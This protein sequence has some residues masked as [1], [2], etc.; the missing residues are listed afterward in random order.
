MQA[1]ASI[2]VGNR[3]FYIISEVISVEALSGKM[4]GMMV[5]PAALLVQEE[6]RLYSISLGGEEMDVEEILRLVPSLREKVRRV[7]IAPGPSKI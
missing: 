4:H 1:D 2:T 7:S 6:E 5:S 3:I